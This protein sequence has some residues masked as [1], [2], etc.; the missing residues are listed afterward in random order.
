MAFEV[1]GLAIEV[2]IPVALAAIEAVGHED[3]VAISGGIYRGLDG[4]VLGRH[5]E[6][7]GEVQVNG[8]RLGII[9]R[10]WGGDDQLCCIITA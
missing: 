10:I 5:M 4:G 2:D 7:S 8:D 6:R 1:D 3:G 9:C